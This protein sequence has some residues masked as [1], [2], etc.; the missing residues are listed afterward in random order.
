MLSLQYFNLLVQLTITKP[1]VQNF[2]L[3][4]S[5]IGQ[6]QRKTKINNKVID[7]I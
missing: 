2:I 4:F 7:K 3:F 5:V 1:E 6:Y